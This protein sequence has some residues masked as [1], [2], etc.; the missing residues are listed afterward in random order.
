FAFILPKSLLR[1]FCGC[2]IMRRVSQP[3]FSVFTR[4]AYAM[5]CLEK[6]LIKNS[7]IKKIEKNKTVVSP[8]V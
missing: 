2:V 7:L 1:N 8:L 5:A 4:I 3:A 6:I